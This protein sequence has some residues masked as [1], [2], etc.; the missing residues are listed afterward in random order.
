M[1][2]EEIECFKEWE[3]ELLR[4]AKL[5]RGPVEPD[6]GR[7]KQNRIFEDRFEDWEQLAIDGTRLDERQ[8]RVQA[9]PLGTVKRNQ[10][11]TFRLQVICAATINLYYPDYVCHLTGEVQGIV[12]CG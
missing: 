1:T 2:D 6:A 12:L 5:Y 9:V 8:R 10:A 4:R 7:E 3:T 11:Q